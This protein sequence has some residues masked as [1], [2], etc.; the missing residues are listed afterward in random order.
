MKQKWEIWIKNRNALEKDFK[1]YLKKGT[2]R[3]GATKIEVEGHLNK[4]KRNLRFS[5]AILD[6]LKDF[7]EWSIISYYYSMYQAALALCA[8]K[9]YKTK[10]HIATISI[11]VKSFYPEQIT[12]EDLQTLTK[13]MMAEEDI[14]EFVELKNYR[15]DATYSISVEYERGLAESLGEK[16]IEF[17]N[18]AEKILECS[19]FSTSL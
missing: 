16:A 1:N 19:E 3:E 9:G 4:A 8:M 12:K 5:R 11:L 18:K 14:K 2:I 7:Y 10:S 6:D 15:E 13:T 17:V